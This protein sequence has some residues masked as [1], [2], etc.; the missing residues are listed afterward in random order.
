MKVQLRS[1]SDQMRSHECS[2]PAMHLKHQGIKIST[3]KSFITPD[4]YPLRDERLGMFSKAAR[5]RAQANG[6]LRLK[7]CESLHL[8]VKRQSFIIWGEVERKRLR[9]VLVLQV[10]HLWSHVNRCLFKLHQTS[11]H[12][13]C[14]FK[15]AWRT[16][17]STQHLVGLHRASKLNQL[18]EHYRKQVTHFSSS[19]VQ[20][21]REQRRPPL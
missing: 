21:R 1:Y 14:V 5:S 2:R 3:L 15:S 19:T 7:H 11:K 10:K 20:L 17:I 8:K 12:A 6:K 4:W 16:H 9:Y 13:Q 18:Q